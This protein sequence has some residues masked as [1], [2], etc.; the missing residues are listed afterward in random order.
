MTG[1]N[2]SLIF[3]STSQWCSRNRSPSRL[4][5]LPIIIII[6]IIIIT[7]FKCQCIFSTAVLIGDTVNKETNIVNEQKLVKNPNW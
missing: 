1:L 2:A 5:F 6:I 7:L 3:L 4:P